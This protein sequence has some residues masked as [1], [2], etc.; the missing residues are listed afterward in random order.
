MVRLAQNV[1]EHRSGLERQ[2]RVIDN[3]VAYLRPIRFGPRGAQNH[4]VHRLMQLFSSVHTLPD[5]VMTSQ[6][7]LVRGLINST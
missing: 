3:F 2:L 7:R 4:T 6:P 5:S 1:D